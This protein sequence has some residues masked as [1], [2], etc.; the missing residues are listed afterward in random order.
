[1]ISLTNAGASNAGTHSFYNR[2]IFPP[3]F[4]VAVRLAASAIF[5]LPVLFFG[6]QHQGNKAVRFITGPSFLAGK[7]SSEDHNLPTAALYN[8]SSLPVF[9]KQDGNHLFLQ[10]IAQTSA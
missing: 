9:C 2:C 10:S 1:M 5:V 3:K 6:C 8:I 4:P 7:L